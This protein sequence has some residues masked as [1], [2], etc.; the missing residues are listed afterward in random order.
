[1][2]SQTSY[3]LTITLGVRFQ[4]VN[5]GGWGWA[6][7][8]SLEESLCHI[9]QALLSPGILQ[10]PFPGP[11]WIQPLL[12]DAVHPYALRDAFLPV[13]DVNFHPS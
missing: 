4:H 8:F 1:M 10:M 2:T 7:T 11:S 3:L 5:F 9:F 12:K 13:S 6:Q